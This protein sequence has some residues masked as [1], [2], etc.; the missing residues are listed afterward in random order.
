MSM[1]MTQFVR[2]SIRETE[3]SQ[4]ATQP[5]RPR[6]ARVLQRVER[7]DHAVG[8]QR[9]AWRTWR[10]DRRERLELV[11]AGDRA[12]PLTHA[13]QVDPVA[14]WTELESGPAAPIAHLAVHGLELRVHAPV[15]HQ[16]RVQVPSRNGAD[17]LA[18]A[19]VRHPRRCRAYR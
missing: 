16:R 12:R 18:A 9:W 2:G 5:D 17:G 3:P 14:H 1:A 11:A 10:R 13:D 8:P 7:A 4:S 6:I 19:T 15:H